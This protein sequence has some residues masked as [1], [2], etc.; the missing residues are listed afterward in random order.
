MVSVVLFVCL[1]ISLPRAKCRDFVDRELIPHVDEWVAKK[2]YPQSLHATLYA[3]GISGSI[4]PKELGGSAP[5]K[6]DYFMELIRVDEFSRTGGHVLG[7]EGINSMAL[8]PIIEHGSNKLKEMVCKPVIRGEKTACLAISEVK[9]RDK[10]TRFRGCL[11]FCSLT[12]VRTLLA[13]GRR[14][15]AMARATSW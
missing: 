7:Q 12:L 10:E 5:A 11:I 6:R 14:L 8:P 1:L 9:E 2:E 15:C 4:Y 13:F 3:A